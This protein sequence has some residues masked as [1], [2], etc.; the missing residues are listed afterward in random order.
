L[1]DEASEQHEQDAFADPKY[2]SLH[3]PRGHDNLLSEHGVSGGQIGVRPDDVGEEATEDFGRM[4]A[5]R[6]TAHAQRGTGRDAKADADVENGKRRPI[7]PALG[8]GCSD[9]SARKSLNDDVTV[10]W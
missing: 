3:G 10:E 2:R 5:F 1:R 9:L 6:R 8:G 4:R 7:G